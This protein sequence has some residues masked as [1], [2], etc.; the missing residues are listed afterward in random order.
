MTRFYLCLN[1]GNRIGCREAHYCTY[2]DTAE[3]REEQKQAQAALV[4]ER[5]KTSPD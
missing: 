1:C 4:R 3:K 2:C 5:E